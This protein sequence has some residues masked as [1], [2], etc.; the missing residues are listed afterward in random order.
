MMSNDTL[1]LSTDDKTLLNFSETLSLLTWIVFKL[2][3]LATMMKQ[4]SVEFIYAG[5]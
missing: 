3:L 5:F 4:S 1:L 2:A